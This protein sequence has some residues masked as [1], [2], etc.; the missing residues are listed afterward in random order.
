MYNQSYHWEGSSKEPGAHV[1]SWDEPNNT[2]HVNSQRARSKCCWHRTGTGRHNSLFFLE[3]S[4]NDSHNPCYPRLHKIYRQL[5]EGQTVA[6]KPCCLRKHLT[7]RRSIYEINM[8]LINIES[9]SI[10]FTEQWCQFQLTLHKMYWPKI[11]IDN[12]ASKLHKTC[13]CDLCALLFLYNAQK[14]PMVNATFRILNKVSL[15]N[16]FFS[17]L[18]HIDASDCTQFINSM[19]IFI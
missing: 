19:H 14:L 2:D 13:T 12:S 6:P 18:I 5:Q 16:Y 7:T 9:P 4:L 11:L 17:K 3:L 8:C 10:T 1:A 15:S